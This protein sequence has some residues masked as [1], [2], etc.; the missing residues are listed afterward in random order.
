MMNPC[1]DF[2]IYY[3][4]ATSKAKK[5]KLLNLIDAFQSSV[6]QDVELASHMMAS[7]ES[8]SKEHK[9]WVKEK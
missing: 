1:S 8:D 2:P 9:N 7:N 3:E 5:L 4:F 6:D